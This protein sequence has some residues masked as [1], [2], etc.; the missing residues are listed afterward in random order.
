MIGLDAAASS[1]GECSNASRHSL[2]LRHPYRD[3]RLVEYVLSIP[4][5]QLYYHGLYKHILRKS[6]RGILPDLIRAR[7]QPTP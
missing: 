6:M 4:A 3:L 1:S 2:E 5:Y 7:R